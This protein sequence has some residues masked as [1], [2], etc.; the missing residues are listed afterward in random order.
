MNPTFVTEASKIIPDPHLLI[1]VISRRVRQL[2]AGH[3]PMVEVSVRM[4][5]A[6]ISLQE[7]I[8]GKLNMESNLVSNPSHR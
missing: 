3:R 4:G 1:N 8:Q 6:D 7:I 2:N 5:L